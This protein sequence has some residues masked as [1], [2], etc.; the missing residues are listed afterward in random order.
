MYVAG[1][2]ALTFIEQSEVCFCRL[3]LA[4]NAVLLALVFVDLAEK[5][6]SLVSQTALLLVQRLQLPLQKTE[7]RETAT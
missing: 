7:K 5:T 1:D 6:V 2:S 3:P 4:N